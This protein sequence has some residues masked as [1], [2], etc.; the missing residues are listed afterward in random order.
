MN[1]DMKQIV[2]RPTSQR[3]MVL[4]SIYRN[5][6]PSAR[7]IYEAITS[8]ARMSFGTV[9]RNLQILV[10]EQEI[11]C[12]QADPEVMRY[13][14]RTDPHYHLHCRKCGK[15]FDAPL[16]YHADIDQELSKN[17]GFIIESHTIVFEGLC[18]ECA[19][20]KG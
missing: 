1:E 10:E 19:D 5:N 14:K 7:E 3:Q 12:V 18:R 4:G 20:S 16:Q 6:H 9:Y 13:D 8:E 11:A 2:R 17:S 15:V